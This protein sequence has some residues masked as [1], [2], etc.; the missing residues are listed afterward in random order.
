MAAN[1]ILRKVG[2]G[3]LL[4]TVSGCAALQEKETAGQEAP[5]TGSN[6]EQPYPMFS[7]VEPIPP[8]GGFMAYAAYQVYKQQAL[9]YRKCMQDYIKNAEHDIEVIKQMMDGAQFDLRIAEIN[10]LPD[11]DDFGML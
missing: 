7:C 1:E 8:G 2:L 6:L 10:G 11:E 3:M 9:E 5:W 4:L